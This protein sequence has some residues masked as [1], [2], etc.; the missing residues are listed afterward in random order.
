MRELFHV[1]PRLLALAELQLKDQPVHQ[2]A[3]DSKA[4]PDHTP[5]E[6]GTAVMAVRFQVQ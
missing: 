1:Q 2:L 6:P 4:H 3:R 5:V